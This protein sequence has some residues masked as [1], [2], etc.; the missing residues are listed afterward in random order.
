MK[1]DLMLRPTKL[2]YV[3]TDHFF[4][5]VGPLPKHLYHSSFIRQSIEEDRKL[6]EQRNLVEPKIWTLYS[7]FSDEK[8]GKLNNILVG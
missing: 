4:H 5:P 8:I 7:N 1:V 3:A 6:Q 2:H